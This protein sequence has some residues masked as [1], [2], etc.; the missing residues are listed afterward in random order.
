MIDDAK[1]DRLAEKQK[2]GAHLR[3]PVGSMVAAGHFDAPRTE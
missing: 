2:A 1:E 3:V